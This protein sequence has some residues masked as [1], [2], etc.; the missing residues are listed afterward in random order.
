M[1]EHHLPPEPADHHRHNKG[2]KPGRRY[3]SYYNYYG[4][5]GGGG[6]A[7]CFAVLVLVLAAGITWL[8]LYVVYRPSHPTLSVTSASVLALYNAATANSATAVAASFQLALVI[9]NPSARC[10]AR[11]DRLAAYVAYRGEPVTAPEPLPPLAQDAG[12]AVEVAPVL[13]GG[14]A[15]AVSPE[16]AEALATDVAYGLLP[17]RV[18]VLGRVRFVSG[19]FHRGWHSLYA[20]CDVLLGVRRPA[21]AAGSP[22]GGGGGGLPLPQQAPLLGEPICN[23]DM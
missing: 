14:Q 1:A 19:P 10:A 22:H 23:V 11:Y 13:G 6:R 7:L 21:A 9:R 3:Y 17:I 20:R 5:D 2:L 18:V 12:A 4:D 15:V 8:V 16:T